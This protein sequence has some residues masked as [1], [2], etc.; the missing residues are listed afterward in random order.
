[1]AEPEILTTAQVCALLQIGRTKLW[2][3]MRENAFP[4]YRIGNGR[5]GSLRFRRSDVLYW[6][7]RNRVS[8]GPGAG[9]AEER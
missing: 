8:H 7:E 1:M 5:N 6:L 3:L 4:A 9:V 2:E